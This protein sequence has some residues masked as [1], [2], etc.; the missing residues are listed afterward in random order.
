MFKKFQSL[1]AQPLHGEK[2]SGMGLYM[3]KLVAEKLKADVSLN[4]KYKNGAE[5]VVRVP[6]I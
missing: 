3:V 6:F 5:M 2:S 1:S 4:E